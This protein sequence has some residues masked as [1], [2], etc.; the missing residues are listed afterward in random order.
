M[1]SAACLASRFAYGDEITE[2]KLAMVEQAENYLH[3]LGFV[4]LRVRV[5]GANGELAR[6]EVASDSVA[7]LAADDVR[8][9]V[10][11]QLK[12]IGFTYVALDL[13]G[14]RSGAMNEVL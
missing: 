9:Q 4:Q 5:H 13:A 11:E 10:L 1:P 2:K 3:Y 6:I 7:R 8:Q 12:H 14:F